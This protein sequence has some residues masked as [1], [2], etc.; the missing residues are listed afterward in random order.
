LP[1][2]EPSPHLV[3]VGWSTDAC[4]ALVGEEELSFAY[5]GTGK[6]VNN[7]TCEDYGESFKGGDV[8]G[9]YLVSWGVV[10]VLTSGFLFS[11]ICPGNCIKTR[12]NRIH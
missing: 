9:C 7:A 1:S 2:D 11:I 10:C 8:I 3:R 12:R 6:K 4:V 5:C